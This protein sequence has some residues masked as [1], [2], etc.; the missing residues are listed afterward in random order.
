[1][2]PLWGLGMSCLF[3]Q[4]VPAGLGRG[5]FHCSVLTEGQYLGTVCGGTPSHPLSLMK[6]QRPAVA[7]K[8]VPV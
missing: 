5:H 8:D 6:L 4:D 2:L 1:M 3:R 7:F